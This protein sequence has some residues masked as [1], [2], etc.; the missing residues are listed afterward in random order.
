[1][2]AGFSIGPLSVNGLTNP[3]AIVLFV[4]CT[5]GGLFIWFV[6]CRR[7]RNRDRECQQLQQRQQP[8]D[9]I[10]RVVEMSIRTGNSEREASAG[11]QTARLPMMHKPADYPRPRNMV[12]SRGT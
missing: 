2:A 7:R 6:C 4:S 9:G 12:Q 11:P 1:M 5:F 3:Q 10:V 8:M